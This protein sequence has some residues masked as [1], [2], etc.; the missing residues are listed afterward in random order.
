MEPTMSPTRGF[1]VEGR[2]HIASLVLRAAMVMLLVGLGV[3]PA[4][5]QQAGGEPGWQILV[6]PYLWVPGVSTTIHTPLPNRPTISSNASFSDLVPD[7]NGFPFEGAAELRY[8]PFGLS[9]DFLHLPIAQNISTRDIFFQGGKASLTSSTGT[10]MLFYRALDSSEQ[11]IDVGA[12]VRPWGFSAKLTLNAGLL[13]TTSVNRNVSWADPLIA[14]RYHREFGNG[15]GVTGYGDVG[16][17]G[18][19]A[20]LDWQLMGTIDYVYSASVTLHAGYRSVHFDYKPGNI[21]GVNVGLDGPIIAGT[22]RF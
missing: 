19:G 5:A 2:K 16:G 1:S 10:A 4:H 11:Y 9:G 15:W 20:D 8:G 6:T 17:F 13:P 12:G 3:T 21:L 18:A 22:I 14:A 7:L